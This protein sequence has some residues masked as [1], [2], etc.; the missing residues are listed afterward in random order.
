MSAFEDI[1]VIGFGDDW[2]QCSDNSSMRYIPVKLSAAPPKKWFDVWENTRATSWHSARRGTVVRN[3]VIHL[4]AST[5]RIERFDLHL[6]ELKSRA[7]NTNRKYREMLE[8]ERKAKQF[9]HEQAEEREK[10][11]EK[12]KQKL[13]SQGLIG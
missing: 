6:A 12:L 13:R 4:Y 2:E 10:Q 3:R 9:E 1:E 7:E 5:D 8:Y 11:D